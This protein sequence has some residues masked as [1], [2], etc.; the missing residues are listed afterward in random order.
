MSLRIYRDT[1]DNH[2]KSLRLQYFEAQCILRR[3]FTV[4]AFD[5]AVM[6]SVD[7][8]IKTIISF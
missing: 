5:N 6:V 4:H 7:M 3:V 8:L 2:M 1:S